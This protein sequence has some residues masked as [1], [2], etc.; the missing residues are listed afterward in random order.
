MPISWTGPAFCH[1]KWSSGDGWSS[2]CQPE[3]YLRAMTPP[4]PA[5]GQELRLNPPR[6][7]LCYEKASLE[8]SCSDSAVNHSCGSVGKQRAAVSWMFAVGAAGSGDVMNHS[9]MKVKLFV[10]LLDPH[11]FF[12]CCLFHSV[13]NTL[14]VSQLNL[15]QMESH[16][17]WSNWANREFWKDDPPHKHN[18]TGQRYSTPFPM[19]P[20][21]FWLDAHDK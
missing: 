12:I 20:R 21:E 15:L 17:A 16:W 14:P 5:H 6:P 10:V 2:F 11:L 4:P 18:L 7:R 3:S 8:I 1:S 19:R 9:V 13:Y